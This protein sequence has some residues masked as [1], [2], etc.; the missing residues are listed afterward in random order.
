MHTMPAGR[1]TNFEKWPNDGIMNYKSEIFFSIFLKDWLWNDEFQAT[2]SSKVTGPVDFQ[3]AR[4]GLASLKFY[5]N[6]SGVSCKVS[7]ITSLL[8][9]GRKHLEQG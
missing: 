5:V 8:L 4:G 6:R 2:I 1:N 9:H 7:M 3:M